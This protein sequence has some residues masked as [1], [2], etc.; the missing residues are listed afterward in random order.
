[1][2]HS[3]HLCGSNSSLEM[4]DHGNVHSIICTSQ[5]CGDYEITSAALDKIKGNPQRLIELSGLA[6][7]ARAQGK[8]LKVF[9]EVSG[10]KIATF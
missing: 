9:M 10:L 8:V 5:D 2:D 1:M 4:K 6:K 3:C 7:R